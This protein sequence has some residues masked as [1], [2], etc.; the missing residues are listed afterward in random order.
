[1]YDLSTNMCDDVFDQA[2]EMV[3]SITN[4]LETKY[5]KITSFTVVTLPNGK[6][7]AS[8]DS[9][10]LGKYAHKAVSMKHHTQ[11][12]LYDYLCRETCIKGRPWYES[13]E[14]STN[15]ILIE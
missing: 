14:M 12:T 9:K 5:K 6:K 2:T 10:K 8:T 3:D 4:A 15:I 7:V 1:M 13:P 11:M